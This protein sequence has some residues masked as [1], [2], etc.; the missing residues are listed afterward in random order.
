[1]RLFIDVEKPKKTWTDLKKNKLTNIIQ[2]RSI[3]KIDHHYFSSSIKIDSAPIQFK[4]GQ[5]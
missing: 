3:V 4:F 2:I 1:M 5:L